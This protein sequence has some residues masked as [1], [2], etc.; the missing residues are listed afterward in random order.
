MG[1]VKNKTFEL[2]N[3]KV[4]V[5]LIRKAKG[6]AA[7]VDEGHVL[8]GGMIEGATKQFCVPKLRNG[9]L[10]NVLTQEE[11]EFF[12]NGKYHGVNLS[13]Y[14]DF[15]RD[16]NVRLHKHDTVL[17]LSNPEDYF[18]YKV[19]LAW[20]KVIAPSLEVYNKTKRP[21]YQFVMIETGEEVKVRGKE[22][23]VT[24]EA[25]KLY[26]KYEDNRDIL[27]SIFYLMTGKKVSDS[28]DIKFIKNQVEDLVDNR[29]RDFVNLVKDAD[30]ETK[31]LIALA[32]NAGII[33]KKSG[34]YE[35]IDGLTLA[36]KGETATLKNAVSYLNDPKNQEVVD[37]IT[38]RLSNMKE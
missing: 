32:E 20:D 13:I 26:A 16:Y 30:F 3:K 23:S 27:V 17:D 37:L 7:N 18:Q 34:R 12:E 15:W 35:T 33:L 10:K 29:T 6:L 1:E 2:P 19:L 11:K 4:T 21:S 14:S 24:K 25:W 36:N 8:S 31:K 38:A 9:G 5:R 22:L 28:S